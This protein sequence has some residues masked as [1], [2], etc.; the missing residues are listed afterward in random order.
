MNEH[1]IVFDGDCPFCHSTVR[2]IL[3]IDRNLCFLFTSLNG[4]EA[5]ILLAEE[6]ERYIQANTLVLI[7]NYR[8]PQSRRFIRSRAIFRIYWLV[9]GRWKWI[10]ALSL[11]PS[12]MGDF[13]YRL[14]ALY[15]HRLNVKMPKEPVPEDRFLS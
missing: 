10:G 9:G 4:G 13:M 6:Y 15:R 14:F 7:E 12:F 1:L 5:R 8:L 2:H 3:A 11:L